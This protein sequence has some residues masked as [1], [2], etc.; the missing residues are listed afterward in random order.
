MEARASPNIDTKAL[1]LSQGE[2]VCGVLETS[3][4]SD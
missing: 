1:R 2:Q 4:G 3:L